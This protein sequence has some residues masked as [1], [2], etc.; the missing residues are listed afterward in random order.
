MA[1]N[2][3][4]VLLGGLAAGV[5]LNIIDGVTYGVVLKDR[6]T[7]MADAFKPGMGAAMMSGNA[8][9]VYII[10]DLIIGLLLVWTYAAVRPRFGPGAGT[11]V[12]V[13]VLFWLF[14]TLI[15]TSSLMTG[16]FTMGF[17][18]TAAIIGL[19]AY[20]VASIVGAAIY[21]EEPAPA[22]A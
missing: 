13:A 7:A 10:T 1:I 21:K 17:F 6:M 4:R 12:I 9:T 5:V 15:N 3:Q 16:M 11:A 20:I 22:A 14:G 2:T 18:W 19:V 8:T